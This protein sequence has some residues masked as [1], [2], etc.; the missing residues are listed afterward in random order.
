MYHFM[1]SARVLPRIPIPVLV[2][3]VGSS[4]AVYDVIIVDLL[5][6]LSS[7]VRIRLSTMQ[8]ADAT[9]VF[10]RART[11]RQFNSILIEKFVNYVFAFVFR[12]IQN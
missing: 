11:L 7:F 3:F 10:V 6:L 8:S 2:V 9:Y 4:S 5:L 1:R 12:H